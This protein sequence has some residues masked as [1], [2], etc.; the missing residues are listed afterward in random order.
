MSEGS[1]KYLPATVHSLGGPGAPFSENVSSL[2]TSD[3]ARLRIA[4][5]QGP[6]HH[7]SPTSP[8]FG[9][10]QVLDQ[11]GYRTAYKNVVLD[12]NNSSTSWHFGENVDMN[13]E[14]N[15][16][17]SV[18]KTSDPVSPPD[19][20]PAGA[21]DSTIVSSGLGPNVSTKGG[22]VVDASPSSLSLDGKKNNPNYH[23][24]AIGMGD[25]KG[26]GVKGKSNMPEA[27]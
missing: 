21:E 18:G 24:T 3:T 12:G 6:M 15:S 27:G 5:S 16:P 8:A 9:D 20:P 11:E 25:V 7:A 17:P 4:Y 23:S 22:P 26:G 19:G 13:Y 1:L 2:S 10:A 14:N